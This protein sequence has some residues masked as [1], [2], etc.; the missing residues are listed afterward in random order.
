[1]VSKP[2]KA[3]NTL[4]QG[5]QACA[6]KITLSTE[7]CITSSTSCGAVMLRMGLPSELRFPYLPSASLIW[8]DC[9]YVGGQNDVVNFSVLVFKVE[10]GADFGRQHE[11]HC[12]L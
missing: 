7:T 6:G 1:M 11:A 12:G 9:F 5:V 4:N 8:T 2:L 10:D 3:P